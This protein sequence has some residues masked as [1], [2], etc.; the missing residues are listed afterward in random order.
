MMGRDAIVYI[1]VTCCTL[2]DSCII[3]KC[4]ARFL[5][6]RVEVGSKI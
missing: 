5:M 3:E 1:C 2:A 4:R 6:M